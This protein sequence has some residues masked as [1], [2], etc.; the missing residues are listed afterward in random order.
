MKLLM[1]VV[2]AI[3]ITYTLA[4]VVAS[5]IIYKMVRTGKIIIAKR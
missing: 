4:D 5:L 2:S 3:C 1:N